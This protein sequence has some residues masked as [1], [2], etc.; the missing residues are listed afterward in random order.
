MRSFCVVER[1][2]GLHYSRVNFEQY[3]GIYSKC[4]LK[5][6]KF[7]PVHCSILQTMYYCDNRTPR[8]IDNLN[9]FLICFLVCQVDHSTYRDLK[10]YK[11]FYFV[12]KSL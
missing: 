3:A 8:Y 10:I 9:H 6:S 12:E 7:M 5:M 4:V 2:A 1:L 11:Y